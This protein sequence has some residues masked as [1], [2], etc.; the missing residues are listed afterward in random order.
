MKKNLLCSLSIL[1]LYSISL[2]NPQTQSSLGAFVSNI[3]YEEAG[4][5]SES[6]MMYGLTG[7]YEVYDT[8]GIRFEGNISRGDTHYDSYRT[9][10]MD[11]IPELHAELRT[12]VNHHHINQKG[13]AFTPYIGLGYRYLDS[14]A[15]DMYSTTGHY[16]Y[17][18]QQTYLYSPIGIEVTTPIRPSRQWQSTVGVEYDYFIHGN[19][20]SDVSLTCGSSLKFDQSSGYGWRFKTSFIKKTAKQNILIEPFYKYWHIDTS[21]VTNCGQYSFIEPR[22]DST[23]LGVSLGYLF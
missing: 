23:E 22:N 15:G 10:S 20:E 5:M 18:R 8:Y 4:L 6:S 11:G 12:M 7:W 3:A 17:D 19:N 1:S 2:A 16:G 21:S 9:G 14:D 13:Y